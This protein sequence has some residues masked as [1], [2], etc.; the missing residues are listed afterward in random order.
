MI[1]FLPVVR[2]DSYSY[3]VAKTPFNHYNLLVKCVRHELLNKVLESLDFKVRLDVLMLFEV[4]WE[5][6]KY[7]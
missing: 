1:L 5:K 4:H 3:E 6:I 7:I 2:C